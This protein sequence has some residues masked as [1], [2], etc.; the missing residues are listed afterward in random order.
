MTTISEWLEG[1]GLAEYGPLFDENKIDVDVLPEI[2]EDDLK[3][4]GMPLG[5][6]RKMMRAIRQLGEPADPVPAHAEAAATAGTAPAHLAE[7][8][9]LAKS[10]LEGERKQ[11]TILF[12]D[13]KGSTEFIE[14]MDAEEADGLLRLAIDGMMA[15]IHRFEGTV[16]KVLGDGIMAIFGAPLAHED[17][18]TRACFAALAMHTDMRAITDEARR[19]FG[20]EVQLRLGMNSGDVI[21]RAIHNDLTMD[22][23]AIGPTVH[24]AARM[25][26][27]AIPGTTR[28]TASTER[29]AEGYIDTKALGPI[30]IKGVSEPLDVF[31]LVGAVDVR[32]R[33][34]A[35]IRRGLSRFVGRDLEIAVLREALGRAAE[36]DG[37]AVSVVGEAGVGKSRLYYE[38]VR[39]PALRQWLVLES[40]SVSHARAAAF[41][42]I[43]DMLRN[44]FSL[45][46]SDEERT[47]RERVMGKLIAMDEDLRG[48]AAPIFALFAVDTGD[49]EW[50]RLDPAQRR[51]RT[52][53]ACRA[54]LLHEAQIQPLVVV[55]EDLHW[56]DPETQAFLDLLVD[57]IA[58]VPILLLFNYRPEYDDPWLSKSYF[59]HIRVTP[60]A[61]QSGEALLDDLLGAHGDVAPLK[62]TILQ[63]TEGNPFFIEESVRGLVEDGALT[64]ARGDYRLALP[65]RSISVPASVQ[66][67]LAARIDRL[68]PEV[69]RLLQIAAVIGKDFNFTL[70][71]QVGDISEADVRRY[72]ESLQASEFLFET[73]LF[74]DPDYT[75]NHAL[76]HQVTYE[77]ML[78]DRRKE[79]HAAILEALEK[80][81]AD[82]P[83]DQLERLAYH[84]MRGEA[85]EKAYEYSHAAGL[86]A[87]ALNANRSALEAYE[88]AAEALAR[89]PETEERLAAAIDLRF[90]IRDE[91]FILAET[92]KILRLMDDAEEMAVKL[93]DQSRLIE[94]L[95]YKSGY[96]WGGGQYVEFALPLAQ[97]AYD[98]AQQVDDPKLV[99][100]ACYRLS[101][102]HALIGNFREAAQWGAEGEAALRSQAETLHRFGGLLYTFVC[103]FHAMASAELGEFKTAD[104]IGRGAYDLAVKSDHAYSITVTSFGIAQSYLL[105][106]RAAESEPIADYSLDQVAVHGV[107]A[108][109]PWVAGRAA[110][111][112]AA[113][114]READVD[115]AIE[116]VMTTSDLS[117]SM[118]HGQAF[119]WAARACL[120]LGR[121]DQAA[122]LANLVFEESSVDDE[123]GARAWAHWVLGEVARCRD[124]PDAA[125]TAYESALVMARPRGMRP[126]EAYCLESQGLSAAAQG[127]AEAAAELCAQA[128]EIAKA[129]SHTSLIERLT[130]SS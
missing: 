71:R 18:A 82:R 125:Q 83:A 30:P 97:R 130:A 118:R 53:E 58:R 26:Q 105:Q 95:L 92:E 48:L 72:L 42:P 29:L 1:L 45:A 22:Y 20:V 9:M 35:T 17:H 117:L 99:G 110:F 106:E 126:L 62:E 123:N 31:E 94:V 69:K 64:G 40:G 27:M 85:W 104:R 66:T 102:A 116:F 7:R 36:G 114:G 39:H 13:I 50:Q 84:A 86:A 109:G 23:D 78:Y 6:R 87:V 67:V 2:A 111:A 41:H 63:R 122:E 19:R 33:F 103:S 56:I 76:T 68:E 60:L 16:N 54:L 15:A 4:L 12:A 73:R 49:E 89:L 124:E 8:A 55:F 129:M 14:L 128:L 91:L 32:S 75:F 80:L 24:L 28:I 121:L 74:P 96:H 93:G 113:A 59:T 107:V 11:V 38:F 115:R 127:D 88:I 120:L 44:Y 100:M 25:E 10:A 79:L 46:R 51:R 70:L 98:L 47:I 37:Q 108:A 43:V 90:R 5:H 77:G 21:V 112:F 61:Q 101:A 119:T 52:L 57:S 65:V 34:H 3:D 81:S